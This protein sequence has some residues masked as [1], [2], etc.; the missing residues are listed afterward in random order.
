[1]LDHQGSR[2]H[3]RSFFRLLG[4]SATSA[5]VAAGCG[6]RRRL[7]ARDDAGGPP[8]AGS[9]SV[10]DPA[11]G[12][13]PGYAGDGANVPGT[14]DAGPY[15]SAPLDAGAYASSPVDAGPYA[16][17]ASPYAADA[18]PDCRPTSSDV[19][20]PFYLAGAP[21]RAQLA[22]Q[23]EPGERLIISGVV[24]DAACN[25]IAAALLDVWQADRDG[26][27]HDA[28]SE[29]RLRGQLM[30][31]AQGRYEFSTIRPGNYALSNGPRPA[32]IHMIAQ[33]PGF[34]PLTTQIYFR[35]DPHLAPADACGSGCNS[36]AVDLIIALDGSPLR[37][38]FD[39]VLARN[40]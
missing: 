18:A 20:G 34:A 8:R 27:Y 12:G 15:A 13:V 31:D 40:A 5:V 28:G 32:H 35:G 6:E 9:S 2:L 39:V 33:R 14:L 24:K 38:S 1:M 11:E 19:L 37:G 22:A 4:V 30:T 16:P 36:G 26:N 29:Y 10:D 7:A 21:S 25:P 3:R 17:G 23:E